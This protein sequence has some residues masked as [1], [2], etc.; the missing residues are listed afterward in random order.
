[1]ITLRQ[2]QEERKK[3]ERERE[4]RKKKLNTPSDLSPIITNT[5][6]DPPVQASCNKRR[7]NLSFLEEEYIAPTH[8]QMIKSIMNKEKTPV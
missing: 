5:A 6:T 1:M 7:E 3:R 8:N 4:R 2:R